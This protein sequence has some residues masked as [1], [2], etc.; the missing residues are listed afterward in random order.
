ME[1]K[2]NQVTAFMFYM[3]NAWCEEE[4]KLVW[5]DDFWPHFW[6]KW[7]HFCEE[8]S[9]FGAV[10]EFYA[11]LSNDNRNK[12]VQRALEVYEGNHDKRY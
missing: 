2:N 11:E 1:T 7:C 4:C 6:N 3:W 5:K 12:L 9:R 10:E 8:H